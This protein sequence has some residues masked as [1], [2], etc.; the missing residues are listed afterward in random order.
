MLLWADNTIG[1]CISFF[2]ILFP[3]NVVKESESL[4]GIRTRITKFFRTFYQNE[5][6]GR[7]EVRDTDYARAVNEYLEKL[8]IWS[9]KLNYSVLS[10]PQLLKRVI[11]SPAGM[12]PL[13]SWSCR[14]L[15]LLP[16]VGICFTKFARGELVFFFLIIIL[17]NKFIFTKVEWICTSEAVLEVLKAFQTV[18][19]FTNR[20]LS[21]DNYTCWFKYSYESIIA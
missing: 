13:L 17:L 3:S 5:L 18:K 16:L 2:K 6:V 21:C 4:K 15:L 14:L 20:R 11:A 10:T 7:P 9:H 8:T 1:N 12:A 19:R